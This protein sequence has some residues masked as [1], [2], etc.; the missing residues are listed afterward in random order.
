MKFVFLAFY[1]V[2]TLAAAQS[3]LEEPSSQSM[4]SFFETDSDFEE[5]PAPADENSLE[6]LPAPS[7]LEKASID[8]ESSN[9]DPALEAPRQRAEQHSPYSPHSQYPKQ[10]LDSSESLPRTPNADDG[11]QSVLVPQAPS[12]QQGQGPEQGRQP[13]PYQQPPRPQQFT[14]LQQQQQLQYQRERENED[15]RL[16][17][18]PELCDQNYE[19]W[20]PAS[21]LTDEICRFMKNGLPPEI[22]AQYSIYT[23]G[24]KLFL[25]GPRAKEIDQ[26]IMSHF[27]TVVAYLQTPF[28]RVDFERLFAELEEVILP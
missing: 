22:R 15:A 27:P 24:N 11:L 25:T 5:L 6:E 16:Y 2:S 13:V 21:A 12:Y 8:N 26:V 28:S 1:L 14:D 10:A 9:T 18:R 20:L 23:R 7:P 19:L 17:C 3:R 4:E